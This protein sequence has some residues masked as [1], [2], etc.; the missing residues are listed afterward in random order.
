MDGVKVNLREIKELIRVLDESD[1][2][3]LTVESDGVRICIRKASALQAGPGAAPAS[4]AAAAGRDPAPAAAP[5]AAAGGSQ[6]AAGDGAGGAPATAPPAAAPAAA[7]EEGTVV[8]RAP[9]V[10]TFYRAPAPDA[11]PF[12]EVGQVVQPGQTLCIIEA[13]KLMNEIEAEVRGRVS[14]ILVENGQPVEYGQ[15]LMT[16]ERL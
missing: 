15:P 8:V 2:A 12:V 5:P 1:V 11:P 3:E 16:L 7:A 4:V 13:M 9:M 10:G 14:A 6:P